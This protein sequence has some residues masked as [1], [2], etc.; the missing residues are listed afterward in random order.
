MTS[1]RVKLTIGAAALFAGGIGVLLAA[2]SLFMEPYF[3]S[4]TRGAFE[5]ILAE[6]RTASR[7]TADGGRADQGELLRRAK[8][9]AAG[10]GCKIVVADREGTVRVS[11]A[12]EFR[13]GQ[14]FPLPKDQLEFLRGRRG[15]L[16]RG[17]TYFGILDAAPRGQSV[18][19][20]AAALRPGDFLVISQ[21]LE[22][23]RQSIRGASPFFLLVGSLILVLEFILVMA[24]SG[25]MAR[26][27][28]ELSEV[29]RRVAGADYSARWPHKRDDELG[30]L[31]D[32]LNEMAAALGRS[33]EELTAAN[34]ELALKVKAQEDFIAGASHEL[35]TPVGLMRGYAEA[36]QLGLYSSN[37]ERDELA[38]VI[39]K[40]ADHL[41]RLVMD[42]AAIAAFGGSGRALLLQDGDLFVTLGAA[43]SRFTLQ[44][45]EKHI[46]LTLAGSGPMPARFDRDRFT[47]IM[48]NLLA[49]GLRHCPE[50]GVLAVRL[51]P[52]DETVLIEVENS[53][54][55]IPEEQLPRLFEPFYRTDASRTRKLG[56]TGL[57]LA[58]VKT[59]TE[60]HGGSC[61]IRNTNSGV[62]AWLRLPRG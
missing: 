60:A 28:L 35:K 24:L 31:G 11:S 12:P 45:R 4:R 57:G 2:N 7:E 42:L 13:E 17:E 62:L 43:V 50:G 48:D 14:S 5:D 37:A 56:G 34:R 16:E 3:A 19:Q 32:S 30:L 61:G 39:L 26:P 27:I 25:R 38:D 58:V 23:L 21:P 8:E 46:T 55:P 9:L 52:E 51:K 41:D 20:L 15:G 22:Q 6:M 10:S 33:I 36:I 29:A 40:E 47:Q 54:E 18:I 59:L 44:A 53:G 49:N 1:I